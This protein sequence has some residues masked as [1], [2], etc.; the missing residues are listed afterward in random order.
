MENL[1]YLNQIEQG[2]LCVIHD[3][4]GLDLARHKR[5]IELGFVNGT[6]L[7]VIKNSKKAKILL[8]G[9]RGFSISL[10]Y[11]LAEKIRVNRGN[12]CKK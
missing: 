2:S 4:V 6:K 11:D 5:L 7:K 8:V 10:D 12:Q 3:K 9:L 1:C